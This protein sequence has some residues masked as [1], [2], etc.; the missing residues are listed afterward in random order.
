MEELVLNLHMHTTYSD[1][2]QTHAEIARAA[3]KAGLD[4]FIT[5]D[6]NILVNGIE[7]YFQEGNRKVLLL[8]GEE[9][10]DPLR[11]P[12]KNHLMVFGA[13][14]ELCMYASDPQRLIDQI[15][16]VN[17]LSFIAHP[18]EYAL[19]AFGEGDL[20]WVDWQVKGYT[21][22]ELWNGLSEFKAV[23]RNLLQVVFH[24]YFP[25]YM[26][27][28]PDERTRRKWDELISSGRR[29]VAVG[30]ADA[31]ALPV[32]LGP[33]HGT[34]YPYEFHFRCINNHLLVPSPLSGE[35][36]ADRKAILTALRLG[37][38]FIGL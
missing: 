37:H 38:L 24:A 10:H 6:H 30:G 17:G 8:V 32:S 20:G 9:I 25:R 16:L 31:H 12:Q 33:L 26:P 15:R 14:R 28:G 13:G 36:A 4:A 3:L 23:S 29:V 18:Y 22:L 21:G 27:H 2:H 1:G 35:I 5:T 11:Q 7:G 34:I 19:P